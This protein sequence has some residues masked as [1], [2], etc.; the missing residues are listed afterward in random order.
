[1][2]YALVVVVHGY[3]KD[4]LGPFLADDVIVEPGLDLLRGEQFAG[5]HT[6][7]SVVLLRHDFGAGGH[8]RIADAH[9]ALSDEVAHFGAALSAEGAVHFFL[10]VAHAC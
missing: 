6:A 10:F 4:F 1:M 9:F 3:G 8:A 2:E 5:F 7:F